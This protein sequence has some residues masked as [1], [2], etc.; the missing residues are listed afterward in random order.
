MA[1]YVSRLRELTDK[2][3][4][5]YVSRKL[6]KRSCLLASQPKTIQNAMDRWPFGA[7]SIYIDEQLPDDD[8]YI[9]TERTKS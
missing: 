2:K 6:Y 9:I 1:E 3:P 7:E 8:W 4:G 5:L